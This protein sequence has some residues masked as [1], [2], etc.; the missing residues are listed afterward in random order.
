LS[1]QDKVLKNFVFP[2][3]FLIFKDCFTSIWFCFTSSVWY[4]FW[5]YISY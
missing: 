2:K 5:D 3:P 4:C 1:V